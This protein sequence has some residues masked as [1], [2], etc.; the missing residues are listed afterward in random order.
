MA[1]VLIATKEI[2][3]NIHGVEYDCLLIPRDN[4]V[5]IDF[6]QCPEDHPIVKKIIDKV[7]KGEIK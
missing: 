5:N 2:M 7:K 3:V 6:T 4:L 1:K